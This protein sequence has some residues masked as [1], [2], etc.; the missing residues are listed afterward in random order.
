MC[1]TR[2]DSYPQGFDCSHPTVWTGVT[3][4]YQSYHAQFNPSQ[5][6]Y[7]PGDMTFLLYCIELY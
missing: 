3:T 6:W 4:D 2:L 5:P 7:I 1:F